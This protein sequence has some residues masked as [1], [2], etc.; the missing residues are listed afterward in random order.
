MARKVLIIT[1][2]VL[3]FAGQALAQ[4]PGR[5]RQQGRAGR[6][7]IALQ[8]RYTAA[9]DFKGEGGSALKFK[10]DLGWGFGIGYNFNEAFNLGFKVSWKGLNYD[11][12]IVR[13]TD[14]DTMQTIGGR[15]DS[16][17]L[18]LTGMWTPLKGKFSPYV[19]GSLGWINLDTNIV[20]GVD[21]GCWWYPYLGY[22]CGNYA[23]T[24][25]ASAT[26]YDLGLGVRL[27]VSEDLFFRVGYERAWTS[28]STYD[29]ADV[30][31]VD[32]GGLL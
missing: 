32:F 28:D 22:V 9:K 11:A 1:I 6:W 31:R 4:L 18:A 14:P 5:Y 19:N 17:N 27:G 25:G 13:T 7:D 10:D 24:Y 3:L 2:L 12:T 23:R 30:F 26:S 8:T 20:S 15:M 29:G 16:S 21:S